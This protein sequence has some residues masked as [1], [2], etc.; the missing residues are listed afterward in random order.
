DLAAE[1][2]SVAEPE[3]QILVCR[4]DTQDGSVDGPRGALAVSEP[5]ITGGAKVSARWR[6]S[7]RV[8]AFIFDRYDA[9]AIARDITGDDNLKLRIGDASPLSTASGAHWERTFDYALASAE[10]LGPEDEIILAG[11]RRHALWTT[12]MSF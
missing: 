2:R 6:Q 7:A 3:D 8:D 11:L 10:T 5:W 1:V 12:L 4:V 9:E